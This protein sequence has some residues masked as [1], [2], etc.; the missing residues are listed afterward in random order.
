MKLFDLDW[1]QVLGEL[2]RWERL[3]PTARRIALDHL[4]P[5]STAS[6]AALGPALKEILASG[7]ATIQPS[8]RVVAVPEAIRGLVRVLRAMDRQ[9]VFDDSSERALVAYLN[10]HFTEIELRARL[11][12]R[13]A[14]GHN[15]A[16]DLAR[17][18]GSEPWVSDLIEASTATRLVAWATERGVAMTTPRDESMRL[19]EDLRELAKLFLAAPHGIPLRDLVARES[20]R[21]WNT[22]LGDAL[23]TGFSMGVIFAGL[24]GTD[25]EPLVGL[26]PPLVQALTLPPPRPP[27]AKDAGRCDQRVTGAGVGS[28]SVPLRVRELL[29]VSDHAS[30]AIR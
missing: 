26:W 6:P 19:L 8:G 27:S 10:E 21:R 18:V 13:G 25:L 24:R 4:K 7:I 15:D 20:D 28:R 5:T 22:T 9:R 16:Y 23:Y 17:E 1:G 12:R 11:G 3:T 2:P 29:R 30:V 14:Y